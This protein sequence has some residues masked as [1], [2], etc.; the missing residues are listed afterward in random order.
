M[1]IPHETI[2][3]GAG[4]SIR[5][6]GQPGGS[7][8]LSMQGVDACSCH[9]SAFPCSAFPS[10][11]LLRSVG[12]CSFLQPSCWTHSRRSRAARVMGKA[13]ATTNKDYGMPAQEREGAQ[14]KRLSF[15]AARGWERLTQENK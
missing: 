12:A 2:E 1:K 4:T 6:F 13:T 14:K 5:F 11:E 15:W 8:V 3:E 7:A 9:G 10:A